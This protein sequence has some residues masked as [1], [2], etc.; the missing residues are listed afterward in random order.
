[1]LISRVHVSIVDVGNLSVSFLRG[2][3]FCSSC[4]SVI[5]FLAVSGLQ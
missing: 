2:I 5:L 1:M 4:S 3:L